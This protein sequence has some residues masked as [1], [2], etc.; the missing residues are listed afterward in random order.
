MNRID[1]IKRNLPRT[2]ANLRKQQE[3]QRTLEF[4]R[5][6]GWQQSGEAFL[7]AWRTGRIKVT[8]EVIKK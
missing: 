8:F 6:V 7:T 4:L 1:Y 2:A 5:S 3:R